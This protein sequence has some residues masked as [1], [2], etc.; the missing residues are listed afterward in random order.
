MDVTDPLLSRSAAKETQ[1]DKIQSIPHGTRR[2]PRKKRRK[3]HALLLVQRLRRAPLRNKCHRR[4]TRRE[5]RALARHP[6]QIQLLQVA[7]RTRTFWIWLGL[8]RANIGVLIP[9]GR[10]WIRFISIHKGGRTEKCSFNDQGIRW[11]GSSNPREPIARA[12]EDGWRL[13]RKA[14]LF[15]AFSGVGLVWR[16]LWL[17]LK[18]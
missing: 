14:T 18:R 3:K 11:T 7:R 4:P 8:G 16:H 9:T 13:H 10:V 5:A 1:Q 17:W 2:E 15:V 6:R 12:G